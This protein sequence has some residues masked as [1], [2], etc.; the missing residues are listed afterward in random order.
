M[1]KKVT[2]KLQAYAYGGIHY[3]FEDKQTEFNAGAG[4]E[5]KIGK[6]AKAVAGIDYDSSGSGANT[7]EGVTSGFLGISISF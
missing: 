7:G 1:S 5:Y 4:L 2:E 6:R 3:E